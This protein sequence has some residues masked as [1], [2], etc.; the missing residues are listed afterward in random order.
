MS[1]AHSVLVVVRLPEPLANISF[2]QVLSRVV[3]AV[4]AEFGSAVEAHGVDPAKLEA[5]RRSL[6]DER[7]S[8][9][10]AWL[11]FK[12]QAS[13]ALLALETGDAGSARAVLEKLERPETPSGSGV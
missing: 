12:H 8:Y 13:I 1:A 5:E 6:I 3:S 9:R 11:R 4:R 2:L 10:D 7:D